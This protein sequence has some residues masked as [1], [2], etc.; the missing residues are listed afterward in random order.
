VSD[1]PEYAHDAHC[2]VIHDGPEPCP[3]H[4]E[5]VWIVGPFNT[6]RWCEGCGSVTQMKG[7]GLNYTG[8]EGNEIT[9]A[10]D[11]RVLICPRCRARV[12]DADIHIHED[13]CSRVNALLPFQP[14]GHKT[15]IEGVSAA[16]CHARKGHAGAHI[17]HVAR[18]VDQLWAET[19]SIRPKRAR[20]WR[21]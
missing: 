7:L 16:P 21:R 2:N 10:N 19:E 17:Y 8:W 15:E 14:C 12:G 1:Q 13:F 3:P 11:T 4:C 20:W 5:H 9:R 6:N 18:Q